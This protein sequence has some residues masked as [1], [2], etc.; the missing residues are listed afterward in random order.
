[1]DM[2][3]NRLREREREGKERK[4]KNAYALRVCITLYITR[5]SHMMLVKD[6]F[7]RF[8]ALH[9]GINNREKFRKERVGRNIFTELIIMDRA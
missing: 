3:F 5:R 2:L 8:I 4:E 6:A 7:L 9:H 1:M